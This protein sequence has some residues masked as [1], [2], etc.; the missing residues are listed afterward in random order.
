MIEQSLITLLLLIGLAGAAVAVV[1]NVR[2]MR[3]FPDALP[4][5]IALTVWCSLVAAFLL[6]AALARV[7]GLVV[8]PTIVFTMIAAILWAS[9]MPLL[10][11]IGYTHG[12]MRE[13]REEE[14]ALSKA[15]KQR[16]KR[17]LDSDKWKIPQS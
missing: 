3:K 6:L 15:Q 1:V 17:Q 14:A 12:R 10:A 4:R 8:G 7:A 11:L 2:H 13:I 16:L 9:G 5:L